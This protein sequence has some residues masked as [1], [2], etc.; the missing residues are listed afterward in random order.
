MLAPILYLM[1]V[2]VSCIISSI[3]VPILTSSFSLNFPSP[4]CFNTHLNL[5]YPHL[6]FLPHSCFNP[7][8]S[9]PFNHHLNPCHNPVLLLISPPDPHLNLLYLPHISYSYYQLKLHLSSSPNLPLYL[10]P[11][12]SSCLYPQGNPLP[13]IHLLLLQSPF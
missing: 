10:I 2:T 8:R 5:P 4:A 6:N 1:V 9:S 12:F 3:R 13:L 11:R 7:H